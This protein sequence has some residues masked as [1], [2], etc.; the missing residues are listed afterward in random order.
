VPD[1]RCKAPDVRVEVV[2]I[3]LPVSGHVEV[4][5]RFVAEPALGLALL[6]AGSE[7]HGGLVALCREAIE[8]SDACKAWRSS[9]GHRERLVEERDRWRRQEAEL[10]GKLQAQL[11]SEQL[12]AALD[13]AAAALDRARAR[14]DLLDTAIGA[15]GRD[16]DE[17]AR[18][19]AKHAASLCEQERARTLREIDSGE[20]DTA[21]ILAAAK[22][23]V[24]RLVPL[25][26][27]RN[28]LGGWNW[29]EGTAGRLT[30]DLLGAPPPPPEAPPP[31][32]PVP[33][34]LPFDP[35]PE[36]VEVTMINPV[37]REGTR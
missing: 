2:G 33:Q 28:A 7:A 3:G 16:V 27:L 1:V 37:T 5:C 25:R 31:P 4:S 29:S 26:N 34:R 17:R 36:D 23:L 18:F 11:D 10:E 15:A 9:V 13:K 6:R 24:S 12:D 30:V 32:P 8:A 21:G 22:D 35:P 19:L 20:L 14:L